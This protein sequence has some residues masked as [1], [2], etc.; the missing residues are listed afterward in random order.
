MLILTRRIRES[1][2]IGDTITVTVLAVKGDQVCLGIN[3]PPGVAVDREEIYERKRCQRE[4]GLPAQPLDVFKLSLLFIERCGRSLVI[5]CRFS[6]L[7][8]AVN[9]ASRAPRRHRL[10]PCRSLPTTQ[11]PSRAPQARTFHF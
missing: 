9:T 6:R 3:A 10:T 1:L 8:S 2:K 5:F 11:N 4:S 7:M